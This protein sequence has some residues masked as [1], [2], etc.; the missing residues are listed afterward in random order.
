MVPPTPTGNF[1]APLRC[2]LLGR[3]GSAQTIE[4]E[5]T[6][7]STQ[8]SPPGNVDE[9]TVDETE[10]QQDKRRNKNSTRQPNRRVQHVVHWSKRLTRMCFGICQYTIKKCYQS[11]HSQ[12][13]RISSVSETQ[14]MSPS[15]FGMASTER[16]YTKLNTTWVHEMKAVRRSPTQ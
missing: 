4:V 15:C 10:I 7:W 13:C 1:F 11:A 2:F 14:Y 16:S 6:V 3:A 5:N 9:Y 12:H 8:K